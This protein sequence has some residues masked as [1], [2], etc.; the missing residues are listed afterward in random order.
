MCVCG[1]EADSGAFEWEGVKGREEMKEKEE[2]KIF[3]F[4]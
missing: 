3:F 4:K 2:K 1:C